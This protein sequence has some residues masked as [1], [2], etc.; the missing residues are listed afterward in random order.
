MILWVHLLVI[1][2][3]GGA[4]LIHAGLTG[5]IPTRS[6]IPAM[7]ITVSREIGGHVVGPRGSLLRFM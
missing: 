1:M 5:M 7:H 6:P 3:D 2:I 4:G